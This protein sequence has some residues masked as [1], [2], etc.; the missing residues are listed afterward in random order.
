MS[1][2]STAPVDSVAPAPF[3]RHPVTNFQRTLSV[4]SLVLKK[5]SLLQVSEK[6]PVVTETGVLQ[7][8]GRF[9]QLPKSSIEENIHPAIAASNAFKIATM[10][11]IRRAR[12]QKSEGLPLM[13]KGTD[14]K[15]LLSKDENEQEKVWSPTRSLVD[16]SMPPGMEASGKEG[17]DEIVNR[18]GTALVMSVVSKG[19]S[20]EADVSG[21]IDKD[22]SEHEEW[23]NQGED[24]EGRDREQE[25]EEEGEL[26]EE[27]EEEEEMDEMEDE[28]SKGID[29][30]VEMLYSEIAE[31]LEEHKRVEKDSDQ[32]SASGNVG[33]PSAV[34]QKMRTAL[35]IETMQNK[36][37]EVPLATYGE[38]SILLAP[39]DPETLMKAGEF[40]GWYDLRCPDWSI[41]LNLE[42]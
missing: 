31:D 41:P 14:V 42:L 26:E 3:S 34:V 28:E 32:P 39:A 13:V 4:S 24:R 11:L 30:L 20:N 18:E 9:N 23:K 6:S 40:R 16:V 10:D 17:V 36:S 38:K 37:A 33:L 15:M 7:E 2:S 5:E 8:E 27:E 1:L 12:R 29:S 19:K 22:G 21:N 35:V 25:E